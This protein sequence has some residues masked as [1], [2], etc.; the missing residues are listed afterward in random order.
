M[1]KD[2]I[3]QLL[4]GTELMR[5]EIPSI[6]EYDNSGMTK[7]VQLNDNVAPKVKN[8][9]EIK[10]HDVKENTHFTG[11][12]VSEPNWQETEKLWYIIVR[13]KDDIDNGALRQCKFKNG[14]WI[15][16]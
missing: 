7:V 12:V 16:E 3:K 5:R 6:R 1:I 11:I 10:V 4:E 14:E 9:Q 2:K 13:I 15:Y 8:T